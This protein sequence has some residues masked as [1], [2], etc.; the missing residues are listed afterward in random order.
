MT[1]HV[2]GE[3]HR[4]QF[5]FVPFL[6]MYHKKLVSLTYL[7]MTPHKISFPFSVFRALYSLHYA[8]VI[9]KS[10]FVSDFCD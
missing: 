6:R 3:L 10:M 5:K 8:L 9:V 4:A 2:P 1:S 7:A